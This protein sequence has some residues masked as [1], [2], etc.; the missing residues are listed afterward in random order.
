MTAYYGQSRDIQGVISRN[1]YSS[2]QLRQ[3]FNDLSQPGLLNTFAGGHSQYGIQ[4]RFSY[5]QERLNNS[6]LRNEAAQQR[7]EALNAERQARIQQLMRKAREKE[8]AMAKHQKEGETQRRFM[9]AKV[10]E[11]NAQN[12]NRKKQLDN[13]LQV[14][15]KERLA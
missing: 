5:Q 11:K 3:G 2:T 14:K 9:V 13:E 10:H 7:Q 6:R 15:S 4:D 8:T 1:H 12:V